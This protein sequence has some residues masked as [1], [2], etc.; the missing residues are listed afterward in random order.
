MKGTEEV[1]EG[2]GEVNDFTFPRGTGDRDFSD[3]CDEGSGSKVD[4]SR[5]VI[6]QRLLSGFSMLESRSPAGRLKPIAVDK[7]ISA[8][9]R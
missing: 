7:T 2:Y 3:R 9:H 1:V 8:R 5:E 4:S 6:P